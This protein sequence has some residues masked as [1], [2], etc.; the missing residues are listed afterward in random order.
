[1]PE[2]P[3]MRKACCRLAADPRERY[4]PLSEFTLKHKLYIIK[5]Q[6]DNTLPQGEL[7]CL[8][9]LYI[10]KGPDHCDEF[11]FHLAIEAEWTLYAD[12]QRIAHGIVQGEDGNGEFT[13]HSTSKWIA[14]FMGEKGRKYIL[15]VSFTKDGAALRTANPRLIVEQSPGLSM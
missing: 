2:M 1:M 12:A 15:E 8:M 4:C 5:M 11:G 14:S 3:H 9:G 13:S 7:N 6:A 10:V